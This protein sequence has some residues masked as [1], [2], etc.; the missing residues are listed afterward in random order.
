MTDTKF[1][2][3]LISNT[4]VHDPKCD[5]SI[6]KSLPQSVEV[7]SFWTYFKKWSNEQY[8]QPAISPQISYE[9]SCSRIVGEA[10]H[11]SISILDNSMP[12]IWLKTMVPQEGH[13]RHHFTV[14]LTQTLVKPYT[15]ITPHWVCETKLSLNFKRPSNRMKDSQCF[16]TQSFFILHKSVTKKNIHMD[17][18]RHKNAL[19]ISY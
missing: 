6:L 5:I 12:W 9:R 16:T 13:V 7:T 2:V 19:L 3:N 11:I 15:P 4:K 10:M 18:R 14:Y 8:I 17:P 1:I